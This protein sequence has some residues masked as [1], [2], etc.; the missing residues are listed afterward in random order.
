MLPTTPYVNPDSKDFK[1]HEPINDLPLHAATGQQIFHPT[2]ESRAF[3]R[4][5]A[6]KVFH[7]KLLPADD[8]VPHP[9]L[10]LM[11]KDHLAGLDAEEIAKRQEERDALV[12]EKKKKFQEREA[13]RMAMAKVVSKPRWDFRITPIKVEDA[14]I[15]GRG[16]KGV[17]WR[18]GMPLMDRSRAAVKIPTKAG[19]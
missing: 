14:G 12:E 16:H 3:T 6:A 8:R 19:H 18:Y 15:D 9:E 17:G 7:D 13:K 10:A 5:D 4:A 2:S 11:H 1:A